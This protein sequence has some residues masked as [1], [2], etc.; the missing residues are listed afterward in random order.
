M[1][2][3]NASIGAGRPSAASQAPD[4]RINIPLPAGESISITRRQLLIGALGV[5]AVVVA[6]AAASAVSNEKK[7]DSEV[8]ALAVNKES[9]FSISDCTV[10]DSA[11]LSLAGEFKMPYGTLVW[12]NSET[13][14][15]CLLPTENSSPLTQAAVLSLSSG[16]YTVVLDGPHSSERG[17]DIYDVRC[18]DQGIIW[19]E[20]N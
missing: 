13:Y 2:G 6:G 5:G 11:P 3:P 20:S 8:D 18:N 15:A 7:A 1:P 12:A 16:Q 9:V 17:F 4:A 14:A 19:I 10:L